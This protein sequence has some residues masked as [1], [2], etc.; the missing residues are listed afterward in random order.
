MNRLHW[1]RH[2]ENLANITKEFSY[3]KTDYSLTPK[4][5]LQ[6]QQTAEYFIDKDIHEIYSSSPKRAVETAEIIAAQISLNIVLLD[7]FLEVNVGALDGQQMN[8]EI[9]AIHQKVIDDWFAGRADTGFPDGE[10]YTMLWD[11]MREGYE[12]VVAHKDDRNIIVVGHGG[13]FKYTLKDFCRDVDPRWLRDSRIPNC[14][15]TEIIVHQREGKLE[16]KL[17]ALASISHLSGAAADLIP[18]L[19][20]ADVFRKNGESTFAR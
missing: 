16:G 5:V 10:D 9:Y 14:S 15:I 6:A 1:V 20:N 12:K 2:G 8:G 4:G 7:N 18:G 3:R 13:N 17:I 19:P 11:R